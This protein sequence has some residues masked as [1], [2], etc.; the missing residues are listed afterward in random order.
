MKRLLTLSLLAAA[1][2]GGCT[3]EKKPT[4]AANPASTVPAG[5]PLLP[6]VPAPPKP[7]G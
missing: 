3:E 4:P 5:A 6:P 7:P 1:V 2:A